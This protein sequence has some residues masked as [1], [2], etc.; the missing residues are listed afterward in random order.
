MVPDPACSKAGPTSRHPGQLPFMECNS[1]RPGEAA[2]YK[3]VTRCFQSVTCLHSAHDMDA[4][5]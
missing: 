1:F 2:G 3:T 5:Q 4:L